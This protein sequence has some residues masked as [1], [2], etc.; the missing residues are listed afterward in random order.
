MVSF[1]FEQGCL[2]FSTHLVTDVERI[3]TKCWC[4][5][6]FTWEVPLEGLKATSFF[7]N[8]Q[9]KLNNTREVEGML[10]KSIIHFLMLNIACLAFIRTMAWPRVTKCSPYD[11]ALPLPLYSFTDLKAIDSKSIELKSKQIASTIKYKWNV[12][13]SW[14]SWKSNSSKARTFITVEFTIHFW[15]M[16]AWSMESAIKETWVEFSVILNKIKR[17][18]GAACKY[19]HCPYASVFP[20]THRLQKS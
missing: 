14:Y 10:Q 18:I 20:C 5:P 19:L 8:T 11:M 7:S 17:L 4:F 13:F 12:L 16:T 15:E 2:R 1:L 6:V 3:V 9:W